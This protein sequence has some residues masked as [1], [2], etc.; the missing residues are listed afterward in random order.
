MTTT[1]AGE[2]RTKWPTS[3]QMD[4]AGRRLAIATAAG[5]LCGLLV[6][7]VGGRLAMM[8]LARLAPE[9]AGVLSDDGF[10]IGQLTLSG[11]LNLLGVCVFIGVLGGGVY[12]AARGLLIGPRWFQ[13]LSISLG[14]AVVVGAMLV[15][16]EGVDFTLLRPTWLAVT[17]FVAIPGLYAALLTVVC[18]RGLRPGGRF[19]RASRRIAL[20]PLIL[21]LPLA[22]VLLV[23]MLG[24]L[25]A[26]LLRRQPGSRD[27]VEHPWVPW[28]L[29]LSLTF[30]FAFSL[31]ELFHDV[32]ALS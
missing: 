15:H 6:G 9:T 17:L 3:A 32:A 10:V 2:L 30:I 8:L 28:L 16:P 12:L 27:L 5:A 7:G 22:P 24:W 26:E 1:S 14:P 19:L 21:W 4:R 18:E 13:V 29:R 25:A 23:G 11:T 31:T 20:T